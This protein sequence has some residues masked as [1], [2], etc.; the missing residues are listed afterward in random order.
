MNKR[1]SEIREFF[2]SIG[3]HVGD[4][5]NK[6]EIRIKDGDDAG[7][8]LFY[9]IKGIHE[10][11]TIHTDG[12]KTTKMTVDVEY[13]GKSFPGK[14]YDYI[15]SN[16]SFDCT[17]GIGEIVKHISGRRVFKDIIREKKLIELGI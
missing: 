16:I 11:S 9:E 1:I 13:W 7:D 12:S 4:K 5:S 17:N 14:S 10:S 8:I 6:F 3:F 2:E 15:C